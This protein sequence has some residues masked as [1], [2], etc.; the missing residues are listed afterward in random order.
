MPMTD[1]EYSHA[2]LRAALIF[3]GKR[4]VKLNFGKRDDPVLRILRRELRESRAVAA[5]EGLK[6]RIHLK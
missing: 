3:A 1:L 2:R 4:I 5:N 6:V